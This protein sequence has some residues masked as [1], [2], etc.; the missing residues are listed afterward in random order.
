[1]GRCK[2]QGQGSEKKEWEG[3]KDRVR[4]GSKRRKVKGGEGEGRGVYTP[5]THCALT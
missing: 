5:W 3:I 1:M 4:E 2:R